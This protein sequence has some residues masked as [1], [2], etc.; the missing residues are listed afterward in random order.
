MATK[1]HP[2]ITLSRVVRLVK[3]DNYRGIC[4][5][6]GKA[7]RGVE[8]DAANYTCSSCGKPAVMGAENI[9]ISIA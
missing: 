3:L 4:L 8:P 7:T 1:P 2:S 5:A 6:C 9:L